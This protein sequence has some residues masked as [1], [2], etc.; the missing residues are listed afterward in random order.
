MTIYGDNLFYASDG[1]IYRLNNP[2]LKGDDDPDWVPL[3]GNMFHYRDSR[4]SVAI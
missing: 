3:N 1:G 4:Y 2:T